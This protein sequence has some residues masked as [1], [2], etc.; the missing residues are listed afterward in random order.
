MLLT[1][2]VQPSLTEEI[3]CFIS[4][5]EPHQALVVPALIYTNHFHCKT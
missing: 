1:V 3:T 2:F 4:Q 5:P